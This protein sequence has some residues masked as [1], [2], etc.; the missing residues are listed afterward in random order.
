MGSERNDKEMMITQV[1]VGGFGNEVNAKML[2][3]YLEEKAGQ[4]WRCRLKRSSTPLEA[5]PEFGVDIDQVQ[6]VNNYEKIEPHAFVHFVNPDSVNSA[7]DPQENMS[8]YST[9]TF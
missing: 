9:T 8:L 4:I 5:C 2:L 3:D 1:S 7:I 6:S